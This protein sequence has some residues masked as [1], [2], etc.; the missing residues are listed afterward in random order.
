MSEPLRWG[1]LSAAGIARKNWEAIRN[2]G[3]G[4]LT[5]VASRDGAKAR[6]FID[7][8]QGQVPFEEKPRAVEG[9]EDLVAADDVD[10]VYVPLPTGLRKEWVIR[11]AGAGKHVMCEKPCAVDAD[12]LRE[13]IEACAANNVQFMD[14]VMFMH[15][16]RLGRLREVLDDGES[17]GRVKRIATAF[18]F[19]GGE[20]FLGSDIRLDSRLEPAGA[21]GDLGWYTI[22]I[23]LF[24]MG[25]A[26]P[27]SVRAT[28]LGEYERNDSPGAVPTEMSAEMFF[29]GGVSATTYNSF[30]TEN[31]EW[32]HVSGTKGHFRV[33]DFVLPY[34][35]GKAEYTIAKPEF[36]V[37]GCRFT[38][39]PNVRHGAVAEESNNHP[40]AQE[41]KLFR[42]FAELAAA[43]RPDP[44][45]PE[46]SLKT[47]RILDACL[48]SAQN[49][50]ELIVL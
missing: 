48:K 9:Y 12:G 30:L 15:S 22:R 39:K 8:C 28:M 36:V 41:T 47:Q 27:K 31:Q 10:A 18:S 34:P 20:E 1:I 49:G 43:G 42:K 23:V 5:A 17:I 29:D 45:W 19:H 40:D 33:D 50:G 37:D 11:A 35:G 6:A 25:Y 46:V 7:E 16:D 3:N 38:M 14:G 2:S 26:M 21:L 13:M 24:V 4:V 44:F 32:V